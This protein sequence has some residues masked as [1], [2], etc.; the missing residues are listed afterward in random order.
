MFAGWTTDD[1]DA[2]TEPGLAPRMERIR[3]RI[4]PKFIQLAE[5]FEPWLAEKLGVPMHT[6]VAKHARRTVH[7]PESTW[8]AFS[9]DPRGYKKH[10]HFQIGLFS[11]HVFAVFGYIDEGIDK[12]AF[13]ARVAAESEEIF[14]ML[15]S[16]FAVIEDHTSPDFK[17]VRDLGADG[18]RRVGERL[19]AVKKAE[20]LV[21][22]T[23]VR[24]EAVRMSGEDFVRWVEQTFIPGCGLYAIARPIAHK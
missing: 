8:V 18:L 7:P 21:G 3:A 15:P 17:L 10:P 5:H 24:E 11:T 13:G 12:A 20:M 19:A 22:R 2:M 1:F 14:A 4:Q 23:I 6:H 16:D 9:A